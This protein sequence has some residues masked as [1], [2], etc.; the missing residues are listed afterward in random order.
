MQDGKLSRIIRLGILEINQK[1]I[2]DS[3]C[4]RL[5]RMILDQQNV[6]AEEIK[7]ILVFCLTDILNL[8][9]EKKNNVYSLFSFCASVIQQVRTAVVEG[10]RQEIPNLPK[11]LEEMLRKSP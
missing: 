8:A 1:K 10:V 2:K 9:V 11:I 4:L 5:A 7:Q 3:L 6:E